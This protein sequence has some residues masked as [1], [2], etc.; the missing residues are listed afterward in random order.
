MSEVSV[1]VKGILS[2]TF[3]CL[4]LWVS[5]SCSASV[6]DVRDDDDSAASTDSVNPVIEWNRSLLAIVRTPGAQPASIHSTRSL[7]ILH[8]AIFDAVNAIDK[9]YQPYAVHL[10]H[11]SREASAK[12][13]ADQAAHDVLVSLYPA[14]ARTLDSELQHDMEQ[15]EDG[16]HKREGIEVGEAVATEILA[17]R[18]DDGSAE[19]LPPFVPNTLPG[20]YRLTPPNFAPADFIQW[21]RVTPFAIASASEFRPA[22]P[23]DL[24]SERDA[25]LYQLL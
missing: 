1:V 18:R 8:A 24:T 4:S 12:A 16:R 5:Q 20:S 23:P 6:T 14:F 15:I 2:G 25:S 10:A 22:P 19:T 17:L 7:A 11:V 9:T 3:L 21:S 13:A